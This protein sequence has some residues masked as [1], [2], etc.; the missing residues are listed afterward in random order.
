MRIRHE[1]M[2]L[3]ALLLAASVSDGLAGGGPL[4]LTID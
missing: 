3:S 2:L 1:L 4:G